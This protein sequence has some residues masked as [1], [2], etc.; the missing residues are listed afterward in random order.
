MAV[1]DEPPALNVMQ[2][3]ITL[4]PTLDL[5]ASCNNAVEALGILQQHP[6]DLLFLDI[7]MPKI[8]GTDFV[9]G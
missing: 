3:H 7:K 6:V 4:V 5:V 2:K 1:D 8:L 9:R